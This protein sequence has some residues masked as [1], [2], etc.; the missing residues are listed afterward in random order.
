MKST[1]NNNPV[2]TLNIDGKDQKINKLMTVAS[3]TGDDLYL[4]VLNQDAT[5]AV[6]STV[7]LAGYT[8]QSAEVWTLNSQNLEDINTNDK[9]NTVAI[10]TSTL[11][12]NS[13]RFSYKYPAHSLTEFRFS[14]QTKAGNHER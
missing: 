1:I 13:N 8:A 2:R 10:A 7:Q 5:D 3:R 4:I 14:K 12:I 9:P 6:T 11:G